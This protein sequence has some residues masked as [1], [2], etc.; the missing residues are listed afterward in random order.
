MAFPTDYLEDIRKIFGREYF[1]QV[2]EPESEAEFWETIQYTN[3]EAVVTFNKGVFNLV[4]EGS[5]ERYVQQLIEG[6]LI[7]SDI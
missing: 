4:S 5:V 7:Q 2:I 6:E 1:S 3:T